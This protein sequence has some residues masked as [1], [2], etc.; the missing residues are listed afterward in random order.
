MIDSLIEKGLTQEEVEAES[1]LQMHEHRPSQIL[2]FAD[3]EPD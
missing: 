1:L 2:D 3:F